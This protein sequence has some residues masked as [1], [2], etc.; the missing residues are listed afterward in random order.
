MKPRPMRLVS[1]KPRANAAAVSGNGEGSNNE[2]RRDHHN[3]IAE[4]AYARY[5]R[6]GRIDGHDLEDWLE[7]EQQ[8]IAEKARPPVS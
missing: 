8:V 6:R 5:E 3:R 1:K 2:P 7:A 4:F